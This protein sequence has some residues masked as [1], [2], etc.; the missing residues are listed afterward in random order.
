MITGWKI[1]GN[2]LHLVQKYAW[3][4]LL[5]ADIICSEKQ[6]IFRERS[7]RKTVNVQVQ[8]M[9]RDKYPFSAKWSLLYLVSFKSFLQHAWF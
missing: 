3:I 1:L 9:S 5:F 4:L 7:L 8:I 6:T 2:S